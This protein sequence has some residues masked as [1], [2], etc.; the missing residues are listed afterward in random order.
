MATSYWPESFQSS[1]SFI[2]LWPAFWNLANL[3]KNGDQS[4]LINISLFVLNHEFFIWKIQL[5]HLI[6]ADICLFEYILWVTLEIWHFFSLEIRMECNSIHKVQSILR[7]FQKAVT[8][9]P[10][11]I[12]NRAILTGRPFDICLKYAAR[13][14][15]SVSVLEEANPNDEIWSKFLLKLTLFLHF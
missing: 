3:W 1:N 2:L 14:S 4:R 11:I 13:W 9:F 15:S 7:I 10:K 12:A 5:S 8:T 6:N